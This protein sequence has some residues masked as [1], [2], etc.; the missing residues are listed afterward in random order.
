MNGCI[1]VF[2]REPVAGRVKTRLAAGVGEEAAAR[3]YAVLLD[4]VLETAADAGARVVLSL[5][6][7]PSPVWAARLGVPFEI[8][9]SGDLGERMADAFAR[10]FA[11]G[12]DRV[13]VIGSDC[14][15]ITPRHLRR[16]FSELDTADA[17]L[18]P[19]ADGGY[20]LVA[21]RPPGVDLFTGVPWSDPE[22]LEA[23]RD[24][25][26]GLRAA[27]TELEEL[28]DIDDE[29]DLKRLLADPTTPQ[30]LARRLRAALI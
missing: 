13:V 29:T 26:T 30:T 24:R 16:A 28:S 10:R 2:G 6:E 27:W 21:Q 25:L 23:T 9:R 15:S 7:A 17:V 1:V 22:T 3:I 18:G 20:F 19:A 5:A 14:P 12:E 8:Q 11:E 4:H